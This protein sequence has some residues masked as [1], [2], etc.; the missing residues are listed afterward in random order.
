MWEFNNLMNKGNL[1]GMIKKPKKAPESQISKAYSVMLNLLQQDPKLPLTQVRKQLA[2]HGIWVSEC[3]VQLWM[4]GKVASIQVLT[5]VAGNQWD[6]AEDFLY[7]YAIESTLVQCL[8]NLIDDVKFISY[9]KLLIS[10]DDFGEQGRAATKKGGKKIK[11]ETFIGAFLA[12]SAKGSVYYW[13]T[14]DL[15]NGYKYSHILGGLLNFWYSLNSLQQ[16]FL[17]YQMKGSSTSLK[18]IQEHGHQA[19]FYPVCHADIHLSDIVVVNAAIHYTLILPLLGYFE[20]I[21]FP[22]NLL[23][24]MSLFP[25]WGT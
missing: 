10:F 15:T 16:G 21:Y 20:D 2:D 6:G 8:T 1:V 19:S 22:L 3:M 12:I 25:N 11:K 4:Y 23:I 7:D 13:K 17:S 5:N 18:A 14:P 9:Y 24:K